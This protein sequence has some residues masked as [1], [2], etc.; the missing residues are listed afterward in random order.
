M[1]AKGHEPERVGTTGGDLAATL[2]A[3]DASNLTADSVL[4]MR[5]IKSYVN[6]KNQNNEWQRRV[7]THLAAERAGVRSVLRDFLLLDHLTERGTIA[8]TVLTDNTGLLRAL[9]LQRADT[10]EHADTTNGSGCWQKDGPRA[11]QD[12]GCGCRHP[13]DTNRSAEELSSTAIHPNTPTASSSARIPSIHYS[14]S[15]ASGAQLATYHFPTDVLR[16]WREREGYNLRE[17]TKM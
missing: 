12:G 8:G 10:L 9:R 17:S 5:K 4:Q 16:W 15:S 3:P 6:F 11:P 7:A 13:S 1:R 2:A 14:S